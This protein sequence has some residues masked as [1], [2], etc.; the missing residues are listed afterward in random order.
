[1]KHSLAVLMALFAVSAQANTAKTVFS[2][3][4]ALPQELREKLV[5]YIEKH[6]SQYVGPN[7][8]TET[9]TTVDKVEDNGIQE[10]QYGTALTSVYSPDGK[11]TE[12]ARFYAE[13][14]EIV[15]YDEIPQFE[16]GHVS[17]EGKD[18]K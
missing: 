12:T 3:D 9:G 16:I 1:M 15:A 5:Q 18:C 13:T 11:H 6:C 17:V 14:L 7:G 2:A 8:M 4:S 10:F